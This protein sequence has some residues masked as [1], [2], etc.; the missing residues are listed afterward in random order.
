MSNNNNNNQDSFEK[1]YLRLQEILRILETKIE[2]ISLDDLLKYY[3]EGLRLLKI[4]R[5]KLT[6]AELKIE[7]ISLNGSTDSNN[8]SSNKGD[9][10][11]SLFNH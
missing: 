6:E 1:A 10:V 2:E 8:S 3:E 5:E 9:T 4:C 11:D 7:K